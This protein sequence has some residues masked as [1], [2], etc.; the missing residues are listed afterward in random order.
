MK[1]LYLLLLLLPA[2]L[3]SFTAC[4]KDKDEEPPTPTPL[5]ANTV[6][7]NP[8]DKLWAHRVNTIEGA[9]TAFNEYHGVELDL[10][11]Q[12]AEQV[13]HVDHGKGISTLEEYLAGL[14]QITEHYYWLD[15]KNLSSGNCDAALARME[16]LLGQQGIK[17]HCI[18]ESSNT[19]QL[20][21]FHNAGFFTSYWIPHFSYTTTPDTLELVQLIKE[22]LEFCPFSAL[23]AAYQM[24]PFMNE[25]FPEQ[26]IHLWT[27]GLTGETGKEVIRELHSH[28]NIKVILVDYDKNFMRE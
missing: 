27:N 3:F 23:S 7:H 2:L 14:S 16:Q 20:A 6:Y 26:N 8:A 1:P 24:Y 4:K 13:F 28:S 11:Y 22:R 21:K 10:I 5:P 15:F 9:N 25:F 17:K 19:T 18:V 12:A